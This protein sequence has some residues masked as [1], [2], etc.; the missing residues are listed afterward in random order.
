MNQRLYKWYCSV[1]VIEIV[2]LFGYEKTVTI[3]DILINNVINV[4]ENV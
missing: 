1:I 2:C 4:Y 3:D